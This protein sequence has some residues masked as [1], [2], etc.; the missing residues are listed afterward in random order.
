[1]VKAPGKVSGNFWSIGQ[2]DGMKVRKKL[3]SLFNALICNAII[4]HN[5]KAATI[6]RKE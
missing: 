3:V 5:S 1:M 4:G 2:M 6:D